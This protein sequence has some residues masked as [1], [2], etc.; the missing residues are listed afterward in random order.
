[1]K[2]YF[3]LC[4][5]GF[6]NSYTILNDDPNVMEAIIV[7]PG[8]VDIAT[9]TLIENGGYKLT[10]VLITHNHSSHVQGLHT[11]KK[12]YTPTVYAAD[13]E[14]FGMNY[15]ILNGDG[16]IRI[17]N[18]NVEFFSIPGHSPDSMVYKI[19]DTLF[20]GD[21]LIPGHIGSTFSRY[22]HELLCNK[23]R[24]KLF[25]LPDRTIIFPGHGSPST[26]ESE[27]QYNMDFN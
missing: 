7:D 6:T 16:M 15:S 23:I 12:I 26:I 14:S 18:F 19:E 24:D 25:S 5:E 27:K 8:K 10:S 21:T 9:I 17:A 11:L 2:V 22:S 4:L 20:T 13:S 1:M 3:N